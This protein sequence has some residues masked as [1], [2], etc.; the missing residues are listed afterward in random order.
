VGGGTPQIG[1]PMGQPG[2]AMGKRQ[3]E[4]KEAPKPYSLDSVITFLKQE[5][6]K[7]EAEAKK[8]YAKIYRTK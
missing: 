5:A 2:E 3:E 7:R 1:A 8:W 4:F 6:H